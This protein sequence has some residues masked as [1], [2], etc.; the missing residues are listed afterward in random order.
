MWDDRISWAG[1]LPATY[2]GLQPVALQRFD[3]GYNGTWQDV[4]ESSHIWA[5]TPWDSAA[6][7]VA[8]GP[9][10]T[11][12]GLSLV[13][14]ASDKGRLQLP[15]FTGL[16][17]SSGRLLIGLW[18]SQNYTM[19]FNPIMSTRGGSGAPLAYLSSHTNGS[20]RHQV[21]NGAGG[22]VLDQYETP[23]WGE[24]ERGFMWVGQM[25]DLDART[26]QLVAINYDK[27]QAWLSPVRALSGIPNA[28]CAAP[29]D[30]AALPAAGYWTGGLFDEV[31]VA[32]PSPSFD[33]AGFV[34][35][36][37]L[38]TWA[39]GTTQAMQGKLA[40]SDAGVQVRAA[41]TLET[42]AER[43]S[44]TLRPAASRP[45][46]VPYWSSDNGVT[47]QTGE[48][49]SAFT[50]LLRW[51]VPLVAGETFAGIDLLPPAPTLAPIPTQVV[52]QRGTATVQ[53]DAAV[54]GEPS[55]TVAAIDL[56]AT[57]SG[58]TLTLRAGWA[59]G[60]IPVTVT[61][62]DSYGRAASRTFTAR[63]EAP[64][65]TPP[66]PPQYPRVP[67]I[68]GD[69]DDSDQ[70]AIIDATSAVVVGEVN[71]ES[72]VTFTLPRKHRAAGL[73]QPERTVQVAGDVY[74]I[75]RIETGRASGIANYEI[76]AE[77]RFYDLAYA[78]QIDERELLQATA[79]DVIEL[80][81]QGTGWT[82]GTVNVTTRRTYSIDE[83]S[84]L[85]LLRTVQKQ[86]GGDLV[87]DNVART[88]SLVVQSGRDVGVAFI[89]GKNLTESRRVVDTTSLVTRIYARNAEGVTIASVNG[90]VPYLEDYTYT[91]EVR[92]ATYDFASGTNP[93]T[94]LSMA[95]A[96]LA[97]RS[98]PATSYVFTVAD[99]SRQ[100]GHDIDRFDVGDTVTVVDDE[101]G[102]RETQ[103]IVAVQH[104]IVQP[105]KSKI[106]LSG[107]LRE[108]GDN[109][110]DEAGALT[111][112]ANNRAF[113]L[114]PFNLLKNARF[115]QALAHWAA[116]GV[117]IVEGSGTGDYAARFEGA[118]T[119]WLE[120][121]VQP[122]N[123]DEY[124]L[125]LHTTGMRYG[126]DV[127]PLRAFVTVEYDD[128]S[129]ETIPVELT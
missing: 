80:A 61:V 108:L 1:E 91:D 30:V 110:D 122:D 94:M 2:P 12:L 16:W 106:T 13:S 115:D 87:F 4:V 107:K 29:L 104:D 56:E 42:G 95:R 83:C 49:P 102:I 60:D 25:L 20:F 19:T 9:W 11:R 17:P 38:G 117:D 79:G 90:G 10:G 100:T 22:L 76:Y 119:R 18:I 7:G 109:R 84:P 63:V 52:P 71:G 99:L 123:R 93:Y 74:R 86:H 35:Q 97:A 111:T 36:M 129:S 118:G 105:W 72:H 15:F 96:T 101:L 67:V 14:P 53:L 78:G 55:W 103:R 59:A 33:L 54:S 47:W 6:Q 121:T 43:V 58:S 75:R 77:A 114:V 51:Q 44:W 26:S 81:L 65:W 32:H 66:A 41:A 45:S 3:D 112:G 98:K 62:R 126:D 27:H 124:A 88:V 68:V 37:R 82:I 39:R 73:L 34:E 113:D 85:E 69:D 23:T 89:Y 70:V 24:G 128:G 116:S 40:V 8:P 64:A 31:L 92:E 57:I 127:P 48:L 50:G 5:A 125:S 120:Q 46:A 21:Y 28:A